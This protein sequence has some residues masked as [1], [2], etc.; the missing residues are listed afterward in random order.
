[1]RRSSA[2]ASILGFIAFVNAHA[3]A[4]GA[5]AAALGAV[6]APARPDVKVV[7]TPPR[8]P[9]PAG[10]KAESTLLLAPPQGI[11]INRFPPVTLKLRAPDGISLDKSEIRQGSDE[12]IEDPE[13][14]PFK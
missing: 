5:R 8:T 4:P 6:A 12:P 1:M 11:K 14:F 3:C 9:V 2:V 13:D 7:I 10:A